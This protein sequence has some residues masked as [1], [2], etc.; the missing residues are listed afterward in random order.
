[1]ADL[2]VQAKPTQ[3]GI[4]GSGLS[5]DSLYSQA[6]NDY[7]QGNLDLAIQE[8]SAYLSNYPGGQKAAAVQFYL[9]DA[10][11]SP[12]QNKL[13]QAIA[14]FTRVINDYPGADQV[15]AALLRRGKA[16]L[17]MKETDNAIA[18]FKDI[19]ARFPAAPESDLAKEQLRNLGIS[20]TKPAPAKE[21]RRK[22][23]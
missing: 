21:T 10:Y 3:G 14:A 16:E 7:V 9:G 18:D 8:F 5:E 1:V 4:P 19:I 13:P 15:P 12:S 22:S 11:S 17:A 2:K 20:T 6:W 23:R